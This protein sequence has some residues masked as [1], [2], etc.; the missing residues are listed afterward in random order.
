MFIGVKDDT[1]SHLLLNSTVKLNNKESPTGDM[2][3]QNENFNCVLESSVQLDKS[4]VK[5]DEHISETDE[6]QEMEINS[7]SR[8]SVVHSAIEAV[9]SEILQNFGTLSYD[10][11]TILEVGK[12][13]EKE[14]EEEE[15]EIAE[16]KLITLK[17]PSPVVHEKLDVSEFDSLP[18]VIQ[19]SHSSTLLQQMHQEMMSPLV[20][21]SESLPIESTT[22]KKELLICEDNQLTTKTS[23]VRLDQNEGKNEFFPESSQNIT[24]LVGLEVLKQNATKLKQSENET[25][26]TEKEKELNNNK[27]S[28]NNKSNNRRWEREIDDERFEDEAEAGDNSTEAYRPDGRPIGIDTEFLVVLK[29]FY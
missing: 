25:A 14:V 16:L 29:Y 19:Q 12:L 13:E 11:K 21:L 23:M 8:L 24:T 28:S 27:N 3:S 1:D 10:S 6:T 7:F 2:N 5:E 9:S 26:E 4:S 20:A 18:T 15:F 17:V 22:V